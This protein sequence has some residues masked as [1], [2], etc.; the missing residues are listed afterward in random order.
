[1]PAHA[2]CWGD[3]VISE[4][5][6]CTSECGFMGSK[7]DFKH[8]MCMVFVGSLG[9][10]MMWAFRHVHVSCSAPPQGLEVVMVG[11]V[12]HVPGAKRRKRRF[13]YSIVRIL[14]EEEVKHPIC[15]PDDAHE[16]E[17][18]GTKR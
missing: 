6:A 5:S 16:L 7:D 11:Q 4:P 3:D 17:S 9:A 18:E 12:P 13:L 8:V 10:H 2:A 1:M 14:L 15:L